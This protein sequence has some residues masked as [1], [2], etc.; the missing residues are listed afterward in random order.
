MFQIFKTPEPPK[1][2]TPAQMLRRVEAETEAERI[3]MKLADEKRQ[4]DEMIRI[5]RVAILS[6]D[7][8]TAKT[9][10]TIK[11]ERIVETT[12]NYAPLLIISGLAVTGQYGSFSEY[13]APTFGT[14]LAKIV[15]GLMSLGLESIALFLGLHAMK[16][17]RRK[18]SAA[19]LI[20]A[21][22][23]IAGLVAY[24]NFDHYRLDSGPNTGT[25][26]IASYAFALFSFVAPFLWRVKIRS[27][28]RDELATNGEIDRRGLKL[29]RVRWITHPIKSFRVYR[30]AAWTGERD[31]TIAVKEWEA[32]AS[33][34]PM[35]SK[36]VSADDLDML[37]AMIEN[38][39]I[40][41]AHD[42]HEDA[43]QLPPSNRRALSVG[44]GGKFPTHHPK[45]NDG[46]AAYTAS[47]DSGSPMKVSDLATE[48]GMSNRVL[49]GKIRE[50]VN[51]ERNARDGH[52]GSDLTAET[53]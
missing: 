13:L 45:W 2:E 46:V 53:A 40:D 35:R 19:G 16:A 37:Q 26:S 20:F 34:K 51:E 12:I 3:R 28:H 10:S 48:L 32:T 29:E 11:R 27:D 5:E 6:A 33:D 8:E 50:Y 47:L 30:L 21:A 22:T 24:L 23:A 38:M 52:D 42:D 44:N 43:N 14:M 31:V 17:L 39:R 36:S 1:S 15:A 18:D 9:E 49:A 25:P 7:T 4:R 41:L